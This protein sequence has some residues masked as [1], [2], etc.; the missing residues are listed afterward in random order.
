MLRN[1][2]I[3]YS[4]V[5]NDYDFSDLGAKVISSYEIE[6][7]T[8][9]ISLKYLDENQSKNLFLVTKFLTNLIMSEIIT[10]HNWSVRCNDNTKGSILTA[11]APAAAAAILLYISLS[12]L[13]QSSYHANAQQQN[14]TTTT[15]IGT[16]FTKVLAGKEFQV[17]NPVA[18]FLGCGFHTVSVVY[19]SPTTLVLRSN[20]Y[21]DPIWKAV[22]LAKK[23]TRSMECLRILLVSDWR[24]S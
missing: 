13:L 22:D 15:L 3:I 24:N 14:T 6:V 21:I 10:I 7:G 4:C 19:L 2:Q 18:G 16:N 1:L 20:Y 11:V 12:S 8:P 23:D 5:D 9:H 17:C